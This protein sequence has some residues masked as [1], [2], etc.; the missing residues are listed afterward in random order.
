MKN[1][2]AVSSL[3]YVTPQGRLITK[4]GHDSE[5]SL[6]LHLRP[7]QRPHVNLAPSHDDLKAALRVI[8]RPWSM[9]RFASPDDAAAAL[10]ALVLS[11]VRPVLDLSPG[12][13]I[14]AAQQAAGKTVFCRALANV[15]TGARSCVHA[16]P[17]TGGID[18]TEMLKVLLASWINAD[19]ALIFDNCKG[20][21]SSGVLASYLTGGKVSGRVLGQSRV[22]EAEPAALVMLSGNQM[23]LDADLLRRFVRVRIDGDTN[24][25]QRAFTFD[26]AERAL[27]ERQEIAQAV[28][29]LLMGYFKAGA[30]TLV[31]GDCGGYKQWVRLCRQPVLWAASLGL[32][33]SIGWGALGDPAACLLADSSLHDPEIEALSDLLVSLNA[34]SQGSVFTSKQVCEWVSM[35]DGSEFDGPFALLSSSVREMRGAKWRDDLTVRS[36]GR[37][38]MNRRDRSV[39][40]LGLISRGL[41]GNAQTWQV[42]AAAG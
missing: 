37:V 41:V 4:P 33:D 42:V 39:G 31:E 27:L 26:P 8:T 34:L 29:T 18:D 21:L 17:N 25:T 28:C 40:G 23:S 12:V 35:A 13:A 20:H 16:L 10:S 3:P 24:P 5:T 2:K 38:L 36:L 22:V 9:Y 19:S 11:V 1:L 7:D 30:P 6:Y 32:T 15:R 14:D